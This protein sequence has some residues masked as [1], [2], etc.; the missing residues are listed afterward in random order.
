MAVERNSSSGEGTTVPREGG[1]VAST[2]RADVSTLVSMFADFLGMGAEVENDAEFSAVR[3][4]EFARR[5]VGPRSFAI[6]KGVGEMGFNVVVDVMF[7]CA[8]DTGGVLGMATFLGWAGLVSAAATIAFA[9]GVTVVRAL[10]IGP[11][12]L[13][14][15]G[16]TLDTKFEIELSP[17]AEKVLAVKGAIEG[18]FVDEDAIAEFHLIVPPEREEVTGVV[19]G[20]KELKVVHP[21]LNPG[22]TCSAVGS[23]LDVSLGLETEVVR[24]RFQISGVGE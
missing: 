4:K 21:G 12:G 2:Q 9:L 18:L 20:G 1:V 15:P 5:G 8:C 23:N 3:G 14:G 16:I 22:T 17:G 13:L 24:D 6:W 10:T 19:L 11:K 7:V